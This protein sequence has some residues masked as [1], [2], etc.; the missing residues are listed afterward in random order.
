[1]EN[2]EPKS[3]HAIHLRTSFTI[4]MHARPHTTAR[5]QHCPHAC[6][7]TFSSEQKAISKNRIVQM[8]TFSTFLRRVVRNSS[9]EK[10]GFFIWP[11]RQ[12]VCDCCEMLSRLPGVAPPFVARATG[13]KHDFPIS[14]IP[15]CLLRIALAN[16]ID[17]QINSSAMGNIL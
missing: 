5:T 8:S 7:N 11:W 13:R 15:G 6:I 14:R 17:S 12:Y 2:V 10:P 9:D 16:Q 1:M 3:V 4:N